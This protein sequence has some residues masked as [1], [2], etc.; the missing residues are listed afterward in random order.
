MVVLAETWN[1]AQ[2]W[3]LRH[4]KP[5]KNQVF[6]HFAAASCLHGPP[7]ALSC[8]LVRLK[9]TPSRARG[10]GWGGGMSALR[11]R[12]SRSKEINQQD[13][14]PLHSCVDGMLHTMLRSL[15]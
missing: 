11:M 14:I 5:G 15:Y 1:T 12:R 8:L 6:L 4:Q 3:L 7:V 13:D 9:F 10:G 2:T